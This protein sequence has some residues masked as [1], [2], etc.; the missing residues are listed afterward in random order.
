LLKVLPRTRSIYKSL[1]SLKKRNS[2]VL[3]FC[4]SYLDL[5]VLFRKSCV[6]VRA[7][8]RDREK[9]AAQWVDDAFP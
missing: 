3:K 6:S 5:G 8:I 4:K 2:E 7:G 1:P 9:L